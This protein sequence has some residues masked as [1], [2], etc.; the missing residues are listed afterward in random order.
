ML[1]V[2]T[3]S[4]SQEEPSGPSESVVAPVANTWGQ[5]SK[6]PQSLG[7]HVSP[8]ATQGS[9]LQQTGRGFS[10]PHT[11]PGLSDTNSAM[12]G[13]KPDEL[14]ELGKQLKVGERT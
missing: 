4:P 2:H 14:N 8:S 1:L 5:R 13:G 7:P 9:R 10:L 6:H 3:S 12:Q 11:P